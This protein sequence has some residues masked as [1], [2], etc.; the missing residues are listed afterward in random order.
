MTGFLV[1]VKANLKLVLRN[2]SSIF[3]FLLIPLISTLILKI[4]SDKAW[5]DHIFKS[6]ITVFDSSKSELSKE[7]INLLQNNDSFSITVYKGDIKDIK[8]AKEKAVNLANK[9]VNNG[10]IYISSD[11]SNSVLKG[12]DKNLVTVLDTESDDRIKIL[13]NNINMILTRFNTYSKIA[14]GNEEIFNQLMKKAAEDKT[15]EKV[16]TVETGEKILKDNQKTQ[17]VNFGYLVAIMSIT[18][19]F[20]GNFIASIFIDEKSNR[21]LKRIMLTKSSI[22]NYGMAKIFVA[23]AALLVQIFMIIVGMKLF[24]RIDVGMNLFEISALILGLGLIFNTL[25]ITLGAVFGSLSNAN[26]LTFFINTVTAMMSGLYFPL[27]ITPKWMQN[28]SLIMPQR[29]IIRTAEQILSGSTGWGIVFGMVVIAYMA[30]F[31][32]IG[33]LGLK[34]NNN[35][36]A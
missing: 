10:F 4:P 8:S 12:D 19:M 18:L 14:G 29:W 9:T 16:I 31:L 5:D 27:E 30:L 34:V 17:V 25:S 28:M 23:V 3:L 15:M 11:F 20:S 1:M 13:E 36:K 22:L 26:Y 33:F 7:F 2:K 35:Y 6:S 21:V 24:V 32:S